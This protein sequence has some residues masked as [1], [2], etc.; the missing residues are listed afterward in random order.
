MDNNVSAL[1]KK[2]IKKLDI[3]G[4]FNKEKSVRYKIL[5]KQKFNKIIRLFSKT[6]EPK[7]SKSLARC[8]DSSQRQNKNSTNFSFPLT[9]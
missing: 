9:S 5:K 7:I 6:T 2:I 4:E 3:E 8:S 1:K